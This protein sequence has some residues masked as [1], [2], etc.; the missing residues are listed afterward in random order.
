MLDIPIMGVNAP[1]EHQRVIRKLTTGLG[2]LFVNGE[3]PYEPFPKVMVDE[4]QTSPT[5]DV[6]LFD[7]QLQQNVVIIEVSGKAGAKKDFSKI[8]EVCDEYEIA[9]GFV[10]DYISKKWRK[11]KYGT[12]EIADTP[13]FCESIGYDLNTFLS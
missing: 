13:S 10:Y 6:L 7:N 5:P 9:E 8:I 3:I 4:S 11:Y 1:K 2:L 12:G